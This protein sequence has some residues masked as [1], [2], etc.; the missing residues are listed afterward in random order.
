MPFSPRAFPRWKTFK[1]ISPQQT[2]QHRLSSLMLSFQHRDLSLGSD[3]NNPRIGKNSQCMRSQ[4]GVGSRV[5]KPLAGK[6]D[7]SIG[8][9]A[10]QIKLQL[11]LVRIRTFYFNG[12]KKT[13]LNLGLPNLLEKAG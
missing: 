2:L 10:V 6:V 3:D 4:T 8:L 7:L 11:A 9:A 5:L 12:K 1:G 13:I